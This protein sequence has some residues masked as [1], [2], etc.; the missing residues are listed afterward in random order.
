[1]AQPLFGWILDWCAG[2]VAVGGV[3]TGEH[4][5]TAMVLLPATALLGVVASFFLKESFRHHEG[6]VG[7]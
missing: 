5:R 1:L 3:Y 7:H 6:P 4:Y 2:G